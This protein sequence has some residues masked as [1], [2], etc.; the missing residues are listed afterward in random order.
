MWNKGHTRTNK[1]NLD[2]V[3]GST[4]N[5][6]WS[7]QAWYW[8]VLPLF[9]LYETVTGNRVEYFMIP[10]TTLIFALQDEMLPHWN[11]VDTVILHIC[12]KH[13]SRLT[14]VYPLWA[15]NLQQLWDSLIPTVL[16]YSNGVTS[17][18]VT[19]E[20]IMSPGIN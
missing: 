19:N 4:H 8:L 2:T 14:F 7:W 15:P 11:K 6:P 5:Q 9:Q 1:T 3:S 13:I 18:S 20:I 10:E 16:Q 12:H 17:V